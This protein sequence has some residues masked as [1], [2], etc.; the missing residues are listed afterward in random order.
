MRL[1]LTI[2]GAVIIGGYAVA[3]A[4]L[5]SD[6]AI[7][8]ASH[9]P[10]AQAIA[11]MDAADQPFGPQPGVL[12]AALGVLLALGW[13]AVVLLPRAG[14]PG[15]ACVMIWGLILACGA[16]AYFCLSFGN[17][18]SV[19]DTFPDWDSEASFA[20]EAPLYIISAAALL[21]GICALAVPALRSLLRTEPPSGV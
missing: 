11:E 5:M 17:M 2:L 9:R 10:L 1:V 12:F 20:L 13:A 4:L 7:A 14:L 8:A 15:W 18:M 3:G 6:W 16:P 19:G 21:M